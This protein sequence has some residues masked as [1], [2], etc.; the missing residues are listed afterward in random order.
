ML[1]LVGTAAARVV[2]PVYRT[3][4]TAALLRETGILPAKIALDNVTRRM[5]IRIRKIDPQHPLFLRGQESLLTPALTR[6]SRSYKEIPNSEQIDPLINPP[7]ENMETLRESLSRIEAPLSSEENTTENFYNRLNSIPTSDIL[8]YTDGS[9]LANGKTGGGFAIFQLGRQIHIDAFPLGTN[10]EPFDAEVHAALR[11]IQTAVSLPTTRFARDLWVFIDNIEVARKILTKPSCISSQAAFLDVLEAL[12]TWKARTRLPH[13]QE[14][15]I[16]IRWVP[17]HSGIEGNEL[18]DKLAK[19]GAEIPYLDKL[20]FSMASLEKW[21]NTKINEDRNSWW[22][23]VIPK[24]YEQLEIRSALSSPIELQLSRKS[25]SRVIAARTGHGDFAT[26]HT[27]FRHTEANLNC[28]CGSPKTPIHF[29]FCR[30]L[31]RRRGRPAGP[32]NLL[33]PKLLGT[34]NGAITLSKW[35]DHSRFFEDI[36]PR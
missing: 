2:L 4:P 11:G 29:F 36:C 23:N 24:L 14:G 18:A 8:L 7:W 30:I 22:I 5:A 10:I 32:I 3:T 26:Y 31:Q 13:V 25:L 17:G 20:K 1:D 35:L 15:H 19:Q 6:F 21:R 27:R 34:P 16:K 12:Q 9:R 28:K 33:I